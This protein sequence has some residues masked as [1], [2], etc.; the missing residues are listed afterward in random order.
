MAFFLLCICFLQPTSFPKILNAA[1][2]T[3]L[4][5]VKPVIFTCSNILFIL[6]TSFLIFSLFSYFR[7]TSILPKGPPSNASLNLKSLLH[8]ESLKSFSIIPMGSSFALS[9]WLESTFSSLMSAVLSP[10]YIVPS[11]TSSLA[12]FSIFLMIVSISRFV[13]QPLDLII[14]IWFIR[15]FSSISQIPFSTHKSC[16]IFPIPFL[17]PFFSALI[18]HSNAFMHS[19]LSHFLLGFFNVLVFAFLIV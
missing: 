3:F 5:C 9:V 19:L 10:S 7:F 6:I 8:L 17:T 14:L 1:C 12:S 16:T 11:F 15:F 13:A 2:I 18:K 4:H